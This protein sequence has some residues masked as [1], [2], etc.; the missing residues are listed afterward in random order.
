MILPA[1]GILETMR[2]PIDRQSGTPLYQ[3]IESWLRQ[4]IQSGSLEAGTRLPATRALAGELGVSRI[5]VKNA[6]AGLESDGL[7]LTQEGS[8]TFVAP[9][10][11]GPRQ[12][13]EGI[14]QNWPLWQEE[15]TAGLDLPRETGY[16]HPNPPGVISFTGV[17]DPREF[18][19]R[20]FSRTIQDVLRRDGT[21][22]LEYGA[23][24]SGYTP[25]R[26]TIVHVLAHQGI[27]AHPN[28]VL[29]TTGSQQALTLV[30]QV[31][32]K[33]GDRVL[34]EK[35]TYNLAVDLFRTLGMKVVSIPIDEAGM[36]VE[37]LEPLLQQHHP[38][39]IYTI[40]NFQN[41]SGVCLSGAR[42]RQ[43]L[44]L[45]ERYNVPILEDDFVGD[46]RYDGRAQPAIKA[47]DTGGHVLYVGT[48][49]KMLMPG[50]RVGYLLANGPVFARLTHQKQVEDLTTAPLMQRVLDLY[51]TVG[52]YQAHLRRS[53][54]RY[55]SRRDAMLAAVRRYL[56]GV[57]VI[58][59]QGGLFLWLKLPEGVTCTA[60]LPLAL[61][62]GVEF[63]PGT[64]FFPEPCEGE[65]FIRLNFASRTE[66]EIE[67]GMRR[68]GKALQRLQ[69][70]LPT[71][72]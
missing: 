67:E 5:T 57:S 41:P 10:L 35:P 17:G 15:A 52:R 65:G 71:D 56:P 11:P 54:R 53:I 25:L 18:P 20:E 6:Y 50:L 48:F 44:A 62:T 68:L 4:N 58:P 14:R 69:K 2:I 24:D 19:I 22:A 70:S 28:E 13:G 55:R 3:Q 42:R 59:A 51:V 9:P 46:L 26:Q 27:Q 31:L 8:G 39:L 63:A 33:P 60:L 34:V 64:R 21:A 32:L 7:I 66:A 16:A 12:T 40:P 43:L 23:F 61:E 49:S 37:A 36:Q 47:L 29:I 38:R 30:C 45:A 1:S 72:F